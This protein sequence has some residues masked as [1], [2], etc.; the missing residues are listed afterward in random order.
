MICARRRG[1]EQIEDLDDPLRLVADLLQPAVVGLEIAVHDARGVRGIEPT[2]DLIE[3]V[4]GVV[5][6]NAVALKAFVK[7]RS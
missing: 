2:R 6:R 1:D 3:D 4:E 5:E 7:G